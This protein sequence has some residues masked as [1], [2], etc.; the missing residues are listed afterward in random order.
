MG[1][2]HH[3]GWGF[4]PFDSMIFHPWFHKDDWLENPPISINRKYIDSF[5]VGF[6]G[7][8]HVS[9]LRGV[10]PT[11]TFWFDFLQLLGGFL[12]EWCSLG[13]AMF[14]F[15]HDLWIDPWVF[16][17]WKRAVLSLQTMQFCGGVS[18]TQASNGVEEKKNA[19]IWG[20]LKGL[21]SWWELLQ[22]SHEKKTGYRC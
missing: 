21:Q 2:S 16:Q 4:S 5:P 22:L 18:L 19:M 17:R 14:F 12:H 10:Y 9:E 6:P 15:C 3:F 1:P 13:S 20:S 11:M 8:S 7:G